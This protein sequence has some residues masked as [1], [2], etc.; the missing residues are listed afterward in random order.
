MKT[1]RRSSPIVWTFG[2]LFEVKYQANW[3]ISAIQHTPPL[4]TDV[5]KQRSSRNHVTG[6]E[7]GNELEKTTKCVFFLCESQFVH[8][9]NLLQ[10]CHYVPVSRCLAFLIMQHLGFLTTVYDT[11]TQPS[12]T[13]NPKYFEKY[14][15]LH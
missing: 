11:I 12:F 8:Y 13:L 3:S 7:C 9:T 2:V 5:S 6:E 14:N 4:S 15:A 10:I 1:S